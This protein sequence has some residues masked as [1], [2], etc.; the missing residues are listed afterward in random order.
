M[1]TVVYRVS[2]LVNI[3]EYYSPVHIGALRKIVW[4]SRQV[5]TSTSSGYDYMT[6]IQAYCL[7]IFKMIFKLLSGA[8]YEKIL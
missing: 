5:T 2:Y 7:S 8:L 3:I 6:K 1:L 4:G